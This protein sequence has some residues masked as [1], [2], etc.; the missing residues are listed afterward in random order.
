MNNTLDAVIKNRISVICNEE[1]VGD[2]VLKINSDV[3]S[4]RSWYTF[5]MK[6]GSLE[7]TLY[8]GSS[9]PRNFEIREKVFKDISTYGILRGEEVV[10]I[11]K[12]VLRRR[13]I[14]LLASYANN[15]LVKL[16]RSTKKDL[17]KLLD[18]NGKYPINPQE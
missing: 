11:V 12:V 7:H 6:I 10:Y 15:R 8:C 3:R 2:A 1:S 14:Y 16:V 4:F 18:N 9:N 13:K 17:E 5:S